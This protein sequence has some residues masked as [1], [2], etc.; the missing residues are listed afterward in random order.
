MN[1]GHRRNGGYS[2]R[3][4]NLLGG[5]IKRP[6]RAYGVLEVF[7]RAMENPVKQVLKSSRA[8]ANARLKKIPITLPTCPF[9]YKDDEA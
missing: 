1:G 2:S 6:T 4:L 9:N 3:T 8:S 5:V 7:N